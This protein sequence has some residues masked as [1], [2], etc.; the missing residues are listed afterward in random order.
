MTAETLGYRG[1]PWTEED[2]LALG[3]TTD[4]VE[5]FDGGLIVTPAPTPQHQH[6][7]RRLANV[8]NEAGEL[9]VYEAVNVRLR[10]GRI[11]IPDLVVVDRIDPREPVVDGSAVRLIAEIVSPSNAFNGRLLKMH[12]YADAGIEWYLLVEPD[13][14]AI[15]L[16]LFRLDGD[17]YT[18][19]AAGGVL[20][21]TEPV[22]VTIDPADLV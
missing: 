21:L 20:T 19:H 18:Q 13:G 6:I 8:L 9:E 11:P 22:A 3:E 14:D 17:H 2:Y 1:I 16:R 15:G 10:A 7:S 4:R 12:H 5:L